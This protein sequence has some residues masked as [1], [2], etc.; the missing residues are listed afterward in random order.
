[1]RPDREVAG[2]VG[3]ESL[4]WALVLIW[5][6]LHQFEYLICGEKALYNLAYEP[7]LR[8][9]IVEVGN[10]LLLRQVPLDDVVLPHAVAALALCSANVDAQRAL[11]LFVFLV[12]A[13]FYALR[14]V[15][16]AR[17]G[18]A[19]LAALRP[20]GLL[21]GGGGGGQLFVEPVV[22]KGVDVN[23]VMIDASDRLAEQA[24]G[25][26]L[27]KARGGGMVLE[28]EEEAERE[29]GKRRGMALEGEKR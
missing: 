22:G 29:R 23:F 17:G 24:A 15:G 27:C 28:G 9:E 14:A 20:G 13:G 5:R 18:A 10:V 1:M 4:R 11:H 16:I 7:P 3:P 25:L 19:L 2:V 26:L 12:G 21:G 6:G 8:G